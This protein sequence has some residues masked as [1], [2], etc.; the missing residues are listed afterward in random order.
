Y[1][2][3]KANHKNITFVP[4]GVD[5]EMF[6]NTKNLSLSEHSYDI[7][8]ITH[9]IIGYIGGLNERIDSDLIEY[10][11]KKREDWNLLLIGPVQRS[12]KLSGEYKNVILPGLQPYDTLPCYVSLFDVCILPYRISEATY[13]INPV[14]LL[15]YL[16]ASKPIV[17]VPI[18]DIIEFYGNMIEIAEDYE[19]FVKAIE[20]SLETLDEK[21][22]Q[23]GLELAKSK[24]WESMVDR[25][26]EK[27][28]EE[29]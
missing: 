28:S 25:M 1:K 6:N 19:S 22:I 20:K 8:N 15:E 14:K 24:T 26:M 7:F 10:I 13:Y 12:F 4:C 3:K 29:I 16:A 23:E 5:F 17:S 27:I 2:A 11:A 21:K 18:P 9:P